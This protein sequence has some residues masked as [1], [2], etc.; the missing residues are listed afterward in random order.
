MK[1]TLPCI[2]VILASCL[3]LD[4]THFYVTGIA[5]LVGGILWLLFGDPNP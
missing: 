3:L 1:K 4:Q 2:G 5:F